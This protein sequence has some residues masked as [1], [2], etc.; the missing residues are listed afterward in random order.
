[1]SEL[2]K[3]Y[4]DN[5]ATTRIAKEVLDEMYEYSLNNVGNASSLHTDGRNAR[6]ILEEKRQLIANKIN[7]ES[8]EIIFTSGGTES[9]N[10]AVKG[11]ARANKEKGNHIITSTIEHPGIMNTFKALQKEGFEVS[12]V[13]VD[14]YGLI[15]L[16]ELESL[17]TEKTILVSI[18]HAN[19][20]IG[21]IQDIEK[22]G[23]LCRD[24]DVLFHTDAVQSFTK[25]PID[26]KEQYIDAASF[27]SHK[28]HGPKGVGALFLRKGVKLDKLFNGG[29]H[30]FRKRPGTENVEGVIGFAKAVDLV[31]CD[32]LERMKDLRNKLIKGLLEIVEDKTEVWLNGHPTERLPNNAHISFMHIEGESILLNL[33]FK[34]IRISTGSACSSKS[35]TSSHVLLATGLKPEQAHG[36]LRLSLSKY[37]TIEEIDYTIEKVREVVEQLRN[38]SP[39]VKNK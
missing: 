37:T 15:K 23:K 16:D 19:N 38:I 25:V 35:L 36:S 12:Y 21:T 28:I 1:M 39:M 14:K 17:I 13:N 6:K 10:L 2:K 7:A 22:I 18:M 29:A 33:D 9:D 20:E 4:L 3:V 30:E 5:A 31:T 34:G 32:D 27:S 11:I 24:N 8:D 26:V